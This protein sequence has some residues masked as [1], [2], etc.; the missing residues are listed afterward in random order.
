MLLPMVAGIA[1]PKTELLSWVHAVGLDALA[2]VLRA[3]AEAITGPKGRHRA[4]RTQP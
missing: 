2:E 3:E 1:A 4:D